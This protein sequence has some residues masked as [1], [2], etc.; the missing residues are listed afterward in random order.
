MEQH[1]HLPPPAAPV[2]RTFTI[3]W[4]KDYGPTTY[5]NITGSNL[6]D[7]S[8]ILMRDGFDVVVNLAATTAVESTP[9]EVAS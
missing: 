4:A 1:D 8:L 5:E 6:V 3:Y 2:P 9:S 7:G